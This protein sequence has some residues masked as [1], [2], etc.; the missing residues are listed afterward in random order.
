[1]KRTVEEY[2]AL[3]YTI[4]ITPDEG[5][6]F[7]KIKEFEGCMSVGNTKADAMAMIE[8]AMREW[9]AVALEDKLDIPLPEAMQ[10]D[11]YSGKFPLRMPKMLH[12]KLAES[13]DSDGI[14]LNQY[15]IMLLSERNAFAEVKRMLVERAPQPCEEPEVE[16]AMT[17]TGAS[18]K[19][20]P[21]YNRQLKVVGA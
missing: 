10:P 15:M 14:S 17:Y 11:R 9:L 4:E 18:C 16:P 8:D 7:V 5:S 20:L 3:P 6:Y 13:A 19:V 1:M 12:K 21:F 2:M